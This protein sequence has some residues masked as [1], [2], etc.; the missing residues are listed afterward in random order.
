MATESNELPAVRQHFNESVE[1]LTKINELLE[2][3][4]SSEASSSVSSTALQEAAA[5]LSAASVDLSKATEQIAA[6]VKITED[7]L[8]TSSKSLEQTDLTQIAGHLTEIN[9][10]AITNAAAITERVGR[11]E[12]TQAAIDA[13]LAESVDAIKNELLEQAVAS[14]ARAS[15]AEAELDTLKKLLPARILKR[16]ETA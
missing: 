3:L 12:A 11:F 7:A 14:E 2:G 15:K 4:R 9:E 1:A 5:T 10:S 6:A 16:L 8:A 13:S